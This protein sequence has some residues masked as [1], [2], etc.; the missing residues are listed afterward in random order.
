[1]KLSNW[2]VL[3]K[4]QNYITTVNI[5]AAPLVCAYSNSSKNAL[6][7]L[8]KHADSPKVL[9]YRSTSALTTWPPVL[10]VILIW[11]QEVNPKGRIFLFRTEAL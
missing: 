2:L 3:I 8:A 10:V 1:M 4:N 7:L 9:N 11:P 6:K 5:L